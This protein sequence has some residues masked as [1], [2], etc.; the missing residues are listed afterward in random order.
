MKNRDVI[1]TEGDTALVR[2]L[3]EHERRTGRPATRAELL[4]WRDV[5]RRIA[6]GL[7]QMAEATS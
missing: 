1:A 4:R 6:D 7:E 5:Y 3:Q 2:V